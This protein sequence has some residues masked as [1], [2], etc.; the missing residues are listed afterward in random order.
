M[1]PPKKPDVESAVENL[2]GEMGKIGVLEGTVVDLKEAVTE[3]RSRM[4][5][6]ERLE[7][8]LN[9][10]DESRKR[11]LVALFQA[12]LRRQY[13]EDD[14]PIVQ[15]PGKQIETEEDRS[16]LFRAGGSGGRYETVMRIGEERNHPSNP[17]DRPWRQP[18]EK[19]DEVSR[20]TRKIEIPLF[21][22]ENTESWVLR[23]EKYFEL[24]E[25]SEEGKLRTVR[26][27]FGGEALLWYR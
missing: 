26:M 11:D 12:S 14:S 24:G 16:G 8:R 5:V 22:G 21:D 18:E 27:C 10:D 17:L 6:L 7:Q 25:F 19:I 2:R 13:E 23:V 4:S 1:A 9:K 20:K 3:I 15:S